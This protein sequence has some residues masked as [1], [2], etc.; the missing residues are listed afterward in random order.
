MRICIDVTELH[1]VNFIS[2]IQR[3]V[4]EV[5]CRWIEKRKDVLLLVS[6]QSGTAFYEVDN[7][8]YWEYYTK[9]TSNKNYVNKDKCLVIDDLG[10]NDIFFDM[11][12]VW[13]NPYKRSSLLSKLKKNGCKIAA[14]IYDIIPITDAQYCHEFTTLCFMEYIGA[15]LLNADLIIS[16]ANATIDAITNLVQG[17]QCTN[18][19]TAVV[20]LGCDINKKQ[21]NAIRTQIMEATEKRKYVLMV[22]TIEPRKNHEYVLNAFEK[23]LFAMDVSLIFAGRVGWNISSFIDRTLKHE[24]FGKRLFMWNDLSDE[25]ITYLYN[26]A[27]LVA[28]PSYNEGFGLPII[29]AI[30]RGVPVLATDIPVLREVGKEYCK[31]FSVNDVESFIGLVKEYISEPQ[32]YEHDKNKLKEYVKNTWDECAEQMYENLALLGVDS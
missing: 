5:T 7:F 14:H 4:I 21:G 9:R 24:Q 30:D 1:K 22:G 12:S 31:Y 29:E 2:G 32:L 13:M 20:P 27:Y 10:E 26:N 6:C 19:K 8:K 16:N 17:I 18:F 11:D 15:H 28:F 23:K 25:E 3:V